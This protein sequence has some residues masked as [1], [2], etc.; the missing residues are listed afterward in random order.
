MARAAARGE[1][2]CTQARQSPPSARHCAAAE[3]SAALGA[4]AEN[5]A[6]ASLGA[7]IN[8]ASPSAEKCAA[9][10]GALGASVASADSD[11]ISEIESSRALF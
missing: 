4:S 11:M 8:E 2:R 1:G 6:A 10:L 5:C 3:D 7:L 9:T